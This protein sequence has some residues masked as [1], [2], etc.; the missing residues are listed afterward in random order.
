MKA[1]SLPVKPLLLL[2]DLE[3]LLEDHLLQ[4]AAFG[5]AAAAALAALSAAASSSAGRLGVG[6][7][8]DRL[9]GLFV[10]R[11]LRLAAL[12]REMQAALRLR[13]VG[14]LVG[15]ERLAERGLGIGAR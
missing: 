6:L 2:H 11:V 3:H 14:E 4:I 13:D 1:L 8:L 12:Q 15:E 9:G 7:R 5:A 10:R